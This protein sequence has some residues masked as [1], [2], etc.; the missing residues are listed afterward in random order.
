MYRVITVAR[1][2]GSGGGAIARSVAER[3]GWKLLDKNLIAAVARTVQVDVETAR[4]FDESVDPWWHR[5]NRSGLWSASI[6]AGASP[7]DAQFFDAETMAAIEKELITDAAG[8]GDCVIVGRG[9]QCVLESCSDALHVF[10]Y[11]PWEQRIARVQKRLA[12]PCDVGELLRSTDRIRA[13][14]IRRYFGRD[15]K[16]PGLYH[17]MISSQL[18][19]EEVASLIIG[20]IG[21]REDAALSRP[22]RS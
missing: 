8:K 10:V 2:Y 22:A 18:G 4:R 16:D 1:E 13:T 21:Y 3:L 14:Y 20:G 9:G 11:A 19:D 12:V 7:L 6:A 17:M 15:W 5:I